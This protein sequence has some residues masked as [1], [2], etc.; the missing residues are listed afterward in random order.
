MKNNIPQLDALN[1]KRIAD[2][3][4]VITFNNDFDLVYEK[5]IS[6]TGIILFHGEI[7]LFKKKKSLFINTPGSIVG[8]NS[9][10]ENVPLHYNCRVKKDSTIIM[11]P[12]SEIMKILQTRN[13]PLF[14]LISEC[15]QMDIAS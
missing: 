1:L 2:F 15:S 8:I 14:K 9:M 13:D 11:L 7:E 4:E 12:K 5:Q 6:N 3:F 10:L